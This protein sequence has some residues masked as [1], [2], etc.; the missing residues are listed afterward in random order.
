MN[1]GS[2]PTFIDQFGSPRPFVT[3]TFT[4]PNGT[5]RLIAYDA[6]SGPATPAS[7][8]TL[9]DPNGAYAAYTRPQGNGNHGQVDVRKP[10]GGTWTAIVFLRDG[11]FTGLFTWSSPPALRRGD[12]VSPSSLTLRPGE[13]G[14]FR[15]RHALPAA[16]ATARTTSSSP[17]APATRPWCRWSCARSSPGS[18]PAAFDGTL[19]GGNGRNGTPSRPAHVRVRRPAGRARRCV[20]R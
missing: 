10:V 15:Y 20:P 9:I 17:T 11:T 12:S 16:R 1:L 2:A 18:P 5:D 6:W 19:F 7:G 14:R 3:T 8:L 4:I 13:T